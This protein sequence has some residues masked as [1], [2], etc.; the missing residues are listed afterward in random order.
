MRR[1]AAFLACT[2]T[3]VVTA[4]EDPADIVAK[5]QPATG[6]SASEPARTATHDTL[7]DLIDGGAELYH[8]FGFTRAVSLQ[9]ENAARS[10]IQ[11][12]LYEMTDAPAAYGVWSLMQTGK[13]ERGTLGQGSL[14]FGYY[15]AFWSGPYFASVTG[16]RPDP[17]TQAEVDRLASELAAYLPR[18]GALPS[19]F[20]LAPANGLRSSRYFRGRIGLSNIP[21]H[22]VLDLL[23]PT[24]GIVADYAGAQLVVLPSPSRE[25]GRLRCG[26]ALDRLRE[27]DAP[28]RITASSASFTILEEKRAGPSVCFDDRAIYVFYGSDQALWSMI[29]MRAWAAN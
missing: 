2:V 14:R 18:D 29:R 7:F 26:A 25:A 8:E 11:I 24:E 19:W 16:A 22:E 6:W 27:R 3:L 21:T 13:Y 28:S 15:V 10:T 12:E 20:A 23:D 5:L 17:A 4:A 1:L 9:F